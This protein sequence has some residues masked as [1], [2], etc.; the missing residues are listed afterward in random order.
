[1]KNK[2]SIKKQLLEAG[3][4]SGVAAS[5]ESGKKYEAV[6]LAGVRELLA[7]VTSLSGASA[8]GTGTYGA[9]VAITMADNS[10]V[11]IES[12]SNAGATF[13]N[14]SLSYEVGVG[15]GLGSR[16]RAGSASPQVQ[17][18]L[19]ELNQAIEAANQNSA[20]IAVS[21]VAA[22]NPDVSGGQDGGG[23]KTRFPQLIE[24]WYAGKGSK[25]ADYIQ[26]KG[27]G[28][29]LMP[30]SSDPLKLNEALK[31]SGKPPVPTFSADQYINVR[32]IWKPKYKPYAEIKGSGIPRSPYSF[33][34]PQPLI[35]ALNAYYTQQ[36]S[37][38]KPGIPKLFEWAVK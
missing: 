31:A 16:A 11:P 15:Y 25:G 26:I 8:D 27:K 4:Q 10:I 14:T 30:S 19:P 24:K 3:Q 28:L 38:A 22:Q 29:L 2:Y 33:E 12:K 7:G 9:D 1:M 18:I 6:T 36:E 17:A 20:A 5:D 13:G 21:D 32:M 23:T 37:E 35:D 34:N